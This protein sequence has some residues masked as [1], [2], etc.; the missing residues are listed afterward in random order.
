MPVCVGPRRCHLRSD[1]RDW[2]LAVAMFAV[3]A[4]IAI[5]NMIEGVFFLTNSH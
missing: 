4:P 1:W 5:V 3:P 2:K